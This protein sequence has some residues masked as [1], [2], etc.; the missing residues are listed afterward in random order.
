MVSLVN[1]LDGPAGFGET[2]V[3]FGDDTS[4]EV[5]VTGVFGAGGI[6]FFGTSCSQITVST[7]GTITLGSG[8]P[9]T[10]VI[11]DGLAQSVLPFI[12][13]F[14]ADVDLTA[15]ETG[16]GPTTGG[17]STGSDRIWLDTD[18][19]SRTV[20]VT[21][22]DVGYY[23]NG[24]DKRNAFQ[25]QLID[26]SDVGAGDFDIVIRY[27]DIQW[28]TGEL[29]DGVGGLGGNA[30]RIG[31]SDAT[32]V[33]T[34]ELPG[35]TVGEDQLGLHA[36]RGVG[37]GS[38]NGRF[39]YDFRDGEI[40]FLQAMDDVL[41]VGLGG[42]IDTNIFD[43][44]GGLADIN[45]RDT[46]V[47]VSSVNGRSG[48]VGNDLELPAILGSNSASL[49][50][51]TD[52]TAFL[53]MTAVDLEDI[54][55][56]SVVTTQVSYTVTDSAGNTSTARVQIEFGD[57]VVTNSEDVVDATDGK[58]SLR[59]AILRAQTTDGADT[60]TF[61][62]AEGDRRLDMNT[63]LGPLVIEAVE[64]VTI[65]GDIE[66]DGIADVVIDGG[67]R[68]DALFMIEDGG[69]ATLVGLGI[70]DTF[71]T[72]GQAA[73]GADGAS[74]D[75]VPDGAD[76]RIIGEDGQNGRDGAVG[77]TGA[78]AGP[79]G[80]IMNAGTLEIDRS[81]ILGNEVV[82]ATGGTGGAG[83]NGSE[84]ADGGDTSPV[85]QDGDL[86]DGQRFGGSGGNGGE[87][88]TTG[89]GG[90]GGQ[91]AEGILNYGSVIFDGANVGSI[92]TLFSAGGDGGA[93]GTTYTADEAA[94]GGLSGEGDFKFG[95]GGPGLSPANKSGLFGGSEQSGGMIVN[96]GDAAG[97]TGDLF[98]DTVYFLH[99]GTPEIL[100]GT[101][102]PSAS[103]PLPVDILSGSEIA[104]PA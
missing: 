5:D 18:A 33:N 57:T 95:D 94:A 70:T 68:S 78:D 24:L 93:P 69:S 85:L 42:R 73:R 80:V 81:V 14:F 50:F 65:N 41:Q 52:G 31:F 25:V 61:D 2:S 47:E 101:G 29:Q 79:T 96:V 56:G 35:S 66:N 84:G 11:E 44:N 45:T 21:W 40:E 39:V 37:N 100:E 97:S 74:G 49:R 87:S 91:A 27:E 75:P 32:G 3:A 34:I 19:A 76:G 8:V 17:T 16:L 98:A 1:G 63:G 72:G 77:G 7:N 22:D 30:A 38:P 104:A 92:G 67:T 71:V 46:T 83:G 23:N 102:G 53:E 48:N 86:P 59:E 103:T 20:T 43:A 4:T 82:G 89:D 28:T 99:E 6:N 10:S 60:I 64:D 13:P 26:R 9:S 15:D 55:P 88:G 58:T 90:D 62:L 12:A 51:N 54:A 36:T